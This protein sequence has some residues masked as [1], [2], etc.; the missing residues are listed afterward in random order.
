MIAFFEN[1]LLTSRQRNPLQRFPLT[2]YPDNSFDSNP[3]RTIIAAIPV[4]VLAPSS[5]YRL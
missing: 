3:P 2:E 4:E 5:I 1:E